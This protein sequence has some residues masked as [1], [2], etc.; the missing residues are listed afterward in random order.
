MSAMELARPPGRRSIQAYGAP[1]PPSS[2]TT[3][4]D[5]TAAALTA[6]STAAA[7]VT[8]G[9]RSDSLSAAKAATL[10]PQVAYSRP[11]DV[12][13][14]AAG[15]RSSAAVAAAATIRGLRGRLN[16]GT[17]HRT[18]YPP[19]PA[20]GER[21][22]TARSLLSR[23][24]GRS[25][26]ARVGRGVA[27]P[28]AGAAS[29]GLGDMVQDASQR[30]TWASN[31][32]SA[33]ALRETVS[34][35]ADAYTAFEEDLV[36]ELN[37]VRRAP[38]AYAAVVEREAA[39]GAPY[40]QD[41][42]VYFADESAVE[43][44]VTGLR[45]H[46]EEQFTVVPAE[47]G[48]VSGGGGVVGGGASTTTTVSR[49]ATRIMSPKTGHV[50]PMEKRK[51]KKGLSSSGVHAT[52]AAA[53]AAAAASSSA[54]SRRRSSRPSSGAGGHHGSGVSARRETV[55]PDLPGAGATV[56]GT[57]APIPGA[58]E[59]L[60]SHGLRELTLPQLRHQFRC[61]QR[62]RAALESALREMR[63][64]Q[65][66]AE[67]ALQA[68]WAAEDEK[69]LKKGRRSV[70]ANALSANVSTS[71][72]VVYSNNTSVSS[73][74][75]MPP[76]G[77]RL[78]H[79]N[80]INF[81]ARMSG[82]SDDAVALRRSEELMQLH[83][84]HEARIQHMDQELRDVRDA[85]QRS[86]AAANVVLDAVRA[87]RE[88]QPVPLVQR[89][90][91]LSLAA[92]DTAETY[93]GDE[94]RVAALQDLYAV[95]R[96]TLV[97]LAEPQGSS[98]A[99]APPS[100][101]ARLLHRLE[102]RQAEAEAAPT[103]PTS[104]SNS[105]GCHS[106]FG[107]GDESDVREHTGTEAVLSWVLPLL[108]EE[109]SLLAGV[110]QDACATYGYVS[111]EVRGVH[112]QAVAGSARSLLLQMILGALTPVLDLS[113]HSVLQG[114]GEAA[115]RVS[116][117]TTAA[118][119]SA[120]ATQCYA[121]VRIEGR[122][123]AAGGGGGGGV[124]GSVANAGGAVISS[125]VGTLPSLPS[126]TPMTPSTPA[127]PPPPPLQPGYGEDDASYHVPAVWLSDADAATLATAERRGSNSGAGTGTADASHAQR[128]AAAAAQRLWP[129]LW[130]GAYTVGC[131]W[132]QVRGWRHTPSF[133]E[134]CEERQ[135]MAGAAT[136][137]SGQGGRGAPPPFAADGPAIVCT[138]L[139]FASGFEEY[140]VVRG[141]RHMS[142]AAARRV[143]QSTP[144]TG[145]DSESAQ[146]QGVIHGGSIADAV[147]ARRAAVDVHS[148]LGVTLLTPTMHP[149]QI[150][151]GDP[152]CRT[153]CVAVRVPYTSPAASVMQASLSIGEDG[154]L[155]TGRRHE[156]SI[157]VVAQVTRQCELTPPHPITCAAE[158]LAQRSPVDPSVWLV[159]VDTA[160]ALQRHSE[161]AAAATAAAGASADSSFSSAVAMLRTD[162][163]PGLPG[164]AAAAAAVPLALH[165]YAKDMN[166]AMGEYEHVAFIRMQPYPQLFGGAAASAS[167]SATATPHATT[168]GVLM[169][170]E[171]RYLLE[172]LAG[173]AAPP[174]SGHA[175]SSAAAT[176]R[177]G[178]TAP[179]FAVSTASVS[180]G[181][182]TLHEPLL[183]R[184][185]VLLCPLSTDLR[186]SQ[187]CADVVRR[188]DA[189]HLAATA[190]VS[191]VPSVTATV[192]AVPERLLRVAVQLPAHCNERW[193]RRR[194]STLRHLQAKLMEE[195]AAEG[196]ELSAAAK[197]LSPLADAGGSAPPRLPEVGGAPP[198]G[199]DLSTDVHATIAAAAAASTSTL[200]S[201]SSSSIAA[202][203]VDDAPTNA[204]TNAS[205][206]RG[207][208]KKKTNADGRRTLRKSATRSAAASVDG[209]A[210]GASKRKQHVSYK[211]DDSATA[212][213]A[214]A[215]TATG[216]PAPPTQPRRRTMS[217]HSTQM[218]PE[219]SAL[220]V[221]ESVVERAASSTLA[222]SRGG[223]AQACLQ[224]SLISIMNLRDLAAGLH[225]DARVWEAHLM[226]VRPILAGER[227]RIASEINKKKGKEQLRLQHDHDD[228]T[229]ELDAVETGVGSLRLAAAAATEALRTR[230]RTQV[231]RRARLLR[232]AAELASIE[233]AA[234][235]FVLRELGARPEASPA[236]STSPPPT[237]APHV[238]LRLFN[239]AAVAAGSGRNAAAFAVARPHPQHALTSAVL[240]YT[241]REG[242]PVTGTS[243]VDEVT[244]LPQ[245]WD[246]TGTGTATTAAATTSHPPHTRG[247]PADGD[248]VEAAVDVY[249]ATCSVP[250]DFAGQ[251]AL[252]IDDEVAVTWSVL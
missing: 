219:S 248:D 163:V 52:A 73:V 47:T 109:A 49:G 215:A 115:Q 208:D 251:A 81:L 31:F 128:A 117:I 198:P 227:E 87:L 201:P 51:S 172:G 88:A 158:V 184:D 2:V 32:S 218:L 55:S 12:S 104:A 156:P 234:P 98:A 122:V 212:A 66:Q 70:A 40:V 165:I 102:Q 86:L 67:V 114:S 113:N 107:D 222:A 135:M 129:L 233:A 19:K 186:D 17:V 217:V 119:R 137:M 27:A 20:A 183:G 153:V 161:A 16:E 121:G 126:M 125:G 213:A 237:P 204:S 124:G 160:A 191:P 24:G 42:D 36:R 152:S 173:V 209:V 76:H 148:T 168:T 162:G 144:A 71:S 38:A 247:T 50:P 118:M 178:S 182:P 100:T 60:R 59:T 169:A 239:N 225:A 30:R 189:G 235:P 37:E 39:V 229:G 103:K 5:T 43:S 11:A 243:A 116:A 62:Y 56:A 89:H 75:A 196:D 216:A 95:S 131:G 214:A 72:A 170:P 145:H 141:C 252:Y 250:L 64:A 112:L 180:A 53:A 44:A 202:V 205:K 45:R 54:A 194:L 8:P 127:A 97:G 28:V 246:V 34:T 193:W 26:L 74:P 200:F 206:G 111:G 236:A 150:H 146:Q 177:S 77:K 140:E 80:S 207:A 203:I 85:C 147:E 13:V 79:T 167:V 230:E 108:S 138:T 232:I 4:A 29:A 149:M 15:G 106:R 130:A 23:Y 22:R 228:V 105:H 155:R 171:W 99:P 154:R 192:S 220:R 151:A 7:S 159:M 185:G 210:A 164:A 136:P 181:W 190:A 58:P 35:S 78:S 221:Y 123:Y 92:R 175:A 244:L 1:P 166:D 41:S 241:I 101:L 25:P 240:E 174:L 142:P 224:P 187:R 69:A 3:T 133:A 33:A 96:A 21:S 195:V 93:Y 242:A 199:G 82:T 18:P 6:P 68:T 120:N 238:T 110:A 94:E 249:A 9:R 90:R 179:S 231:L 143:V 132:Q 188:P 48:A 65:R 226:R 83:N 84:V 61:Q 14:D 176:A 63:A 245:A 223:S 139:L 46:L 134:A 211:E 10:A 91:G 157:R 197:T 57:T